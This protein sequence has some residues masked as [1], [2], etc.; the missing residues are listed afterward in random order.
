MY[1]LNLRLSCADGLALVTSQT[2]TA[3]LAGPVDVE[4]VV[5]AKGYAFRLSVP[6]TEELIGNGLPAVLPAPNNAPLL[7]VALSGVSSEPPVPTSTAYGFTDVPPTTKPEAPLTACDEVE[8]YSV[9]PV[10]ML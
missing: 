6:T 4:L 9:K 5:T 3:E 10:G 7:P 2:A 1:T 8:T